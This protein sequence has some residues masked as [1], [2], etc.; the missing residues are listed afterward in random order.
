MTIDAGP[1]VLDMKHLRRSLG[2][3]CL[4]DLPPDCVYIGRA[5]TRGG[6]PVAVRAFSGR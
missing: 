4:E 2:A 5:Q 1:R 3:R 6:D